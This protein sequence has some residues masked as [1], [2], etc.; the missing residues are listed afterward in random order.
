MELRHEVGCFLSMRL[1][2][3]VAIWLTI[4]FIYQGYGQQYLVGLHTVWDDSFREWTVVAA[5]DDSTIVEGDMDITW[6]LEND[7]TSYD[8]RLGE[9]SG[10]IKQVFPKDPK[11][12]QLRLG[13]ELVSIRQTW[14]SDPREWKVSMGDIQFTI[15]TRYRD[16]YDEWQLANDRYGEFNLYSDSS[17]HLQYPIVCSS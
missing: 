2:T 5:V 17:S 1:F 10:D 8:F 13:N 6:G 3:T 7:F 12:W 16:S 15:R 11:N 14:P 4:T 9:L